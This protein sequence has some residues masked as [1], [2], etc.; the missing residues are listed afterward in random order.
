MPYCFWQRGGGYDRNVIDARTLFSM[1]EY[2]HNN[3]VRRGLVEDAT[4][5]IWSSAR[6]YAGARDVPIRMDPL[7]DWLHT[8]EIPHS[9]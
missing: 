9:R 3:P 4:D 1:I 5:W 6:F 8:V 7:P 2:I